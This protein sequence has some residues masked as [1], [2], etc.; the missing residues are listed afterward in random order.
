MSVSITVELH[1]RLEE[2][3]VKWLTAELRRALA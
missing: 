3:W 2:Q 1:D